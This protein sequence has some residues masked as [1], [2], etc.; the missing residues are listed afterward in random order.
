M[1]SQRTETTND[2]AQTLRRGLGILKLLA[3]SSTDGLGVGDI[4]RRMGLSKTTGVRLT[5]ALLD[6][7]FVTQDTAT[8]RY[9]LGP[10]AY[11]VG[12]AVEPNYA[13]QAIAAPR[14]RTLARET[15]YWVFFTIRHGLDAICIFRASANKSYPQAALCVGDRH[16]LGLGTGGLAILAAMPD[17][18]VT[19]V[20]QTNASRYIVRHPDMTAE[21]IHRLVQQTRARGYAVIPGTLAP[22]YWG[23]GIPLLRDVGNP[24]AAVVLVSAQHLSDA[25]C[26]VL[27]NRM[28]Q[29]GEEILAG[30]RAQLQAFEV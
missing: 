21:V 20:L 25:R 26:T 10:Q 9:R 6:E 24:V 2:S 11:A 3:R 29:L 1:T 13:L 14:L 22:G 12:L 7:K 8:R 15:G 23:I 5:R 17:D 30:A 19:R 4:S 16:P 28:Q 18:E 27:G